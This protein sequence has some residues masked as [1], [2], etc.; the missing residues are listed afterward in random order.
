MLSVVV[1]FYKA[2][3]NSELLNTNLLASQT[4]VPRGNTELSSYNALGIFSSND[5]FH[6][7]V[8]LFKGTLFSPGWCGSV[9]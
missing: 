3:E 7:N 1:M 8:S 9:D 6:V 4:I 5:E 2:V